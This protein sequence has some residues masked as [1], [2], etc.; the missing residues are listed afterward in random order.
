MPEGTWYVYG[1]AEKLLKLK[2]V[3]IVDQVEMSGIY[4]INPRAIPD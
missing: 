1:R 4:E 2:V 3:A